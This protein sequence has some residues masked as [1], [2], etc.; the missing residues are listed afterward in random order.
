MNDSQS[1]T[2]GVLLGFLDSPDFGCAFVC[3]FGAFL[4]VPIDVFV[5]L[6]SPLGGEDAV[7]EVVL[8]ILVV[9]LG[10]HG[11]RAE[12]KSSESLELAMLEKLLLP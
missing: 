5:V 2:Q 10:R 4:V 1:Q 9:L 12:E 11:T 8:S 3:S 7:S 6:P